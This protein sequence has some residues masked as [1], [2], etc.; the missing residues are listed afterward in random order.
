SSLFEEIA[1]NTAELFNEA[2]FDM[3]YLDAL[4]GEDVIAGPQAGWYYGSKFV[5]D[6]WKHLKRSVLMEMSTFHHHL[7][8]VRSRYVALDTPNRGYKR[9]IDLHCAE[10]TY[11]LPGHLGWWSIQTWNRARSQTDC[12]GAQVEPT[13]SDDIEYLCS[14]C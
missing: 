10:P 6:I 2:G 5:F 13:F 4:D 7:W 1:R 11:G 8:Y 14:K 12:V 9:F 3:I